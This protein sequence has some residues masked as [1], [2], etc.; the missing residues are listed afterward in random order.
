MAAPSPVLPATELPELYDYLLKF[1]LIGDSGVGKSCLLFHFLNDRVRDPSPH[2]IGVEFASTLMRLPSSIPSPA[3]D[4]KTSS[5]TLKVQC[6]DSAG[7]ERFRSVTRNYYRG[8]C[9]AAIVYDITSRRSFE[10]LSTWLADARN[11]AS[12]D[13]EVCIVGNKLDQAGEREVSY[14]EASQWAQDNNAAFVE[15][16]SKNGDNVEKPFTLLARAIL[17]AIES[18]NVDPDRAGSGV[19]YGEGALRRVN[20]WDG[21]LSE[22]DKSGWLGGKCC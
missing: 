11:L 9:G 8:A 14:E 7:Q 19:S 2:T 6:W 18:G 13:L 15:A 22:G 21:K 16:S 20:A 17:G 3:A 10:N 12:P 1:I 5:K 4:P